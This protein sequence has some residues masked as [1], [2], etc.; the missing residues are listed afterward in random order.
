MNP[1]KDEH[2]LLVYIVPQSFYEYF[3]EVVRHV[4]SMEAGEFTHR[5]LL[6]LMHKVVEENM[7]TTFTNPQDR[8]LSAMTLELD[9]DFIENK[10]H[11]MRFTTRKLNIFKLQNNG[12]Y[13]EMVSYA[14]TLA[15]H[16]KRHSI[17]AK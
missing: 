11:I 15:K 13:R 3:P 1:I 5:P 16:A 14:E 7:I 12:T 2:G 9:G 4:D 8:I 6:L 17:F 10:V